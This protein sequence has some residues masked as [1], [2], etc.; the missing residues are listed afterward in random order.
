MTDRQTDRQTQYEDQS[1][2]SPLWAREQKVT[3]AA[4]RV[5][6][7]DVRCA[8]ENYGKSVHFNGENLY[9]PYNGI[10]I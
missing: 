5:A 10:A 8:A 6:T 3:Y 4:L 7:V 2:N 9:S 1:L